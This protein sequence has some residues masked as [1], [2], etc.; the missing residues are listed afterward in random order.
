[1]LPIYT[2]R[3]SLADALNHNQVVIVEGA[4]GSGK[5][6]HLP[7]FLFEHGL[8]GK[9]MIG[10]TEPRRMAAVSVANY[11]ADQTRGMFGGGRVS[12]QV[13]HDHNVAPQTVIKY[14]TTGILLREIQA[15]PD[16]TKYGAIMVDEA[17]ERDVNIDFL[18]GLLKDLLK[19]RYDLKVIV[20]SA[21]ID[22]EKFSKYFGDAPIIRVAGR[23]HSVEVVYNDE[24]IS[25]H[26]DR[27]RF[28]MYYM[29]KAVADQVMDIHESRSEGDVLVFMSGK[30]DINMVI[31]MLE[32]HGSKDLMLLPAYGGLTPDEQNR[33][34]MSWPGKRKVI[35]ATN[36]AETSITIDGV[37]YVVDSGMIRQTHFHSESGIQSLDYIKH[38][39]AGCDQRKGRA[40]RTRPGVCFRMYSEEDF[41]ARPEFTEPEI[42]RVSIA[43]VVLA[44][45]DISIT[46][47]E[48]FDFIDPPDRD[49]FHEAYETLIALGAI[50]PGK[51]GI[52]EIG[53]KMATLPLDPRMARMVL[54]ADKHGCVKDVA[55][56]ASFLSASH[57]FVRP[58]DKQYEADT[59]HRQFRVKDS[60]ILGYLKI[61]EEYSNSGFSGRWCSDNF[62]SAKSMTEVRNVREQLLSILAECG[63]VLTHSGS[64]E[65]IMMSVVAGLIY[66]LL[67]SRGRHTYEGG[68]RKNIVDVFVHPGSVL[69]SASVRDSQWIVATEIVKTTKQFA[70]NCTKVQIGW[71]RKLM[72]HMF[73]EETKLV[74]LVDD[75]ASV[76]AVKNIM[77]QRPGREPQV[78]AS[79]EVFVTL[80]EARRIQDESVRNAEQAGWQRVIFT[81]RGD[82]RYYGNSGRCRTYAFTSVEMHIPYYCQVE[83]FMG[84]EYAV[85]KLRLFDLRPNKTEV[86][87]VK[88]A[89]K[90]LTLTLGGNAVSISA[91]TERDQAKG[92]SFERQDQ[93]KV[94]FVRGV[95]VKR[96]AIKKLRG[97]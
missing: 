32:E 10:V 61:W 26:D 96:G 21:T 59:A 69:F 49:A 81:T 24:H 15:D 73:V 38:S 50:A 63:L 3:G 42:R 91:E 2:V 40:G 89:A 95:P 75:G 33:I 39:R 84:R 30:D 41:Q 64:D 72:P 58:K 6:T 85:P 17:H 14:M 43:G 60:D 53:T 31:E 82:D 83:S 51:Q 18:L 28:T 9:G 36:I 37:V 12:Y 87:P 79:E 57:I 68:F 86:V 90:E 46:D 94:Q 52:T 66:N 80:E 71:L 19:R 27:G 67:E 92:D 55:I 22:T 34:F 5:T 78:V 7:I 11:V 16:L 62:I 70:R 93:S 48:G 44:M 25:F 76:S 47:V 74:S 23:L 54:E 20:A 56:V 88:E 29:A 65:Q 1:M 77:F 35:V 45:E 8:A 13:R 4:T 97:W